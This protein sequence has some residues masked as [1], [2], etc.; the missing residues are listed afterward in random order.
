MLLDQFQNIDQ[1]NIESLQ[2]D[3]EKLEQQFP[4]LIN[5]HLGQQE[6]PYQK[7][8]MSLLNLF[9]PY[10]D[11]QLQEFEAVPLPLPTTQNRNK[12]KKQKENGR[13][14]K[15]ITDSLKAWLE[16]HSRNPYPSNEE[17]L[18]LMEETGL[19]RSILSAP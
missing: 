10:F 19:Q 4:M 18:K 6:M 3:T 16:A 5:Q 7:W 14:S 12:P 13:F 15:E 1:T 11:E 17:K 9:S 2:Q 8:D